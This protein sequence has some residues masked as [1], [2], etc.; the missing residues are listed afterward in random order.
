MVIKKGKSPLE[1]ECGNALGRC[2]SPKTDWSSL[3]FWPFL[4]KDSVMKKQS[5]KTQAC[6]T[7]RPGLETAADARLRRND[8]C[9]CDQRSD[10]DVPCPCQSYNESYVVQAGW[11]HLTLCQL[12][13]YYFHFSQCL[14]TFDIMSGDVGL[15]QTL[16]PSDTSQ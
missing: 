4:L 5:Y 3:P 2:S 16:F 6:W 7:L 1:W 8:L 11:H 15:L 10:P 12:Q 14:N 13:E 9:I